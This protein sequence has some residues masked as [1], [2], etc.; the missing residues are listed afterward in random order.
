MF[1][2]PIPN[3]PHEVLKQTDFGRIISF[4]DDAKRFHLEPNQKWL[5]HAVEDPGHPVTPGEFV[6]CQ[7]WLKNQ[8]GS[9]IVIVSRVRTFRYFQKQLPVRQLE[10]LGLPLRWF[11]ISHFEEY[12]GRAG[13]KPDRE[14]RGPQWLLRKLATDRS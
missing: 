8:I 5:P 12:K 4:P 6:T 14:I 7:D 11:E 2:Q 3:P 1:F 9:S 13:F 10:I